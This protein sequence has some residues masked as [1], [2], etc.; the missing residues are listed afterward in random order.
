[1]GWQIRRTLVTIPFQSGSSLPAALKAQDTRH[2]PDPAAVAVRPAMLP[3][4]PALDRQQDVLHCRRRILQL[5][6]G[7]YDTWYLYARQLRSLDRDKEAR[8][9]LEKAMACTE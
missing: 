8:A 3:L 6:P 9:A 5:E 7:D 4:Y 1:M 2:R